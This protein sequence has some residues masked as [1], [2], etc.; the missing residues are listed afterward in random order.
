MSLHVWEGGEKKEGEG[1]SSLVMKCGDCVAWSCNNGK[2]LIVWDLTANKG[3]G[4]GG[5]GNFCTN[6]LIR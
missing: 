2:V 4:K 3:W 1:Y 6:L 5:G